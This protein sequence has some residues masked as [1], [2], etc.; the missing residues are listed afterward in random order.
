[1]QSILGVTAPFFA[2]VLLGWVVAYRGMLP[3]D[4]VPGL[5]YFVLLFALPCMLFRFSS[6][7]PIAQL[8]DGSVVLVYLG[9]ALAIVLLATARARQSHMDWND[10]AFGALVAVFP[11]SGF[12]GVP[13]VV[14]LLGPA[15]AAPAIVALALDMVVTSSLCIALAQGRAVRIGVGDEHAARDALLRSLR[16]MAT[17]PLPWAIALGTLSSAVGLLPPAPLMRV[18]DM[19][20]AAASPV[21]LFALGAM[22]ARK[23]PTAQTP[24]PAHLGLAELVACKLLLHPLLVGV[25]GYMAMRAGLPIKPFA[26]AVLVLIA[27]LPSASNVPMLAE[28]FGANGQRLARV[29]LLSTVSAFISFTAIVAGLH[30]AA[31]AALQV[32]TTPR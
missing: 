27:A 2:L 18:V 26:V 21:A 1:V 15:A 7:T 19:L 4:A 12:M 8:L 14:A 6:T 25:A 31:P 24:L 17:N 29:V 5:N 28:R 3:R 22:L 16:R 23:P 32:A 10:A 11:N 13:L 9:S 30:V 20:A